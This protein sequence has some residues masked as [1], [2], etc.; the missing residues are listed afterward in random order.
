MSRRVVR[1][2]LW[3]LLAFVVVQLGLAVAVEHRWPDVRDPEYTFKED[4]LRRL[5]SA[6]PDHALI[7]MLGSSRG[8][9]GFRA[10]LLSELFDS[11]GVTVFNAALSGGGPVLDLVGLR[12]LLAAGL[13]PDLLLVEVVPLHF[14]Q[15]DRLGLEERTLNGARLR[16]AELAAL[17]PYWQEPER[18]DRQW[19]KTRLLPGLLQSAELRDHFAL[20][21]CTSGANS[22]EPGRLI[23]SH[24]WHA[25]YPGLDPPR[26]RVATEQALRQYEPY[27]RSFCLAARP[28][29]ALTDLLTACRSEDIPVILVLMPEAA[30]FRNLYSPEVRAGLDRFLNDFGRQWQ[31]PIVDART[32]AVDADFWDSHHLL[33][34]GAWKVTLRL[35]GDVLLP[36]LP[37]CRTAQR[38]LP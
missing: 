5:R 3:F 33:P 28:V 37:H 23:D 20:D 6:K 1:D 16:Q 19:W 22:D 27:A 14:N 15:P 9:V 13:R 11:Y 2:L 7:L 35:G 26:Q 31:V 17:R 32:W 18:H 36:L 12:R 30:V 25:C 21:A 24:G 4:R 29:Q 8:S 34:P 38:G 10:A